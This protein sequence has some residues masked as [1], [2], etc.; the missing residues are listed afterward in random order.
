MLYCIVE[1]RQGRSVAAKLIDVIIG[2]TMSIL[3]V[4]VPCVNRSDTYYRDVE[5]SVKVSPHVSNLGCFQ[6]LLRLGLRCGGVLHARLRIKLSCPHTQCL[7]ILKPLNLFVVKH[8][9][10]Q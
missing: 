4:D 2:S 8:I 7:V 1:R 6:I 5:L 9:S 3:C 10:W